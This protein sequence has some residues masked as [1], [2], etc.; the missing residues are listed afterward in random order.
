MSERKK[1]WI[2]LGLLI[3]SIAIATLVIITSEKG[4]TDQFR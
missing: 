4:F 3:V 1:F 2:L